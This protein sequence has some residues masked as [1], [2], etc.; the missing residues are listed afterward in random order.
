MGDSRRRSGGGREG[1]RSVVPE[2]IADEVGRLAASPLEQ[3][4]A[5]QMR[6]V[7]AGRGR[8]KG[9]SRAAQMPGGTGESPIPRPAPPR[10]PTDRSST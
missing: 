3:P 2:E 1:D 7:L 4:A 6:A 8:R 5:H 9:A 10:Q